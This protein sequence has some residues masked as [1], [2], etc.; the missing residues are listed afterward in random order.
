MVKRKQPGKAKD[1]QKWIAN[2]NM[3][4]GAFTS[5]AN[6][7]DM[8]VPAFAAEVTAPNS[9]ASPKTKKQA[10]LA[11]TFAKFKHKKKAKK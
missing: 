7:A 3:K 4:E 11:K 2:M 10:V 9:K 6:A 1:D 8:S 5:K